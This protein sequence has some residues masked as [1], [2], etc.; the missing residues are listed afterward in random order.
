MKFIQLKDQVVSTASIVKVDQPRKSQGI[1]WYIRTVLD[2][3]RTPENFI[4]SFY[5]TEAEARSEYTRI[6][7]QLC[8]DK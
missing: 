2:N 8:S 1:E 3:T 4:Q 6:V 7:S 5:S